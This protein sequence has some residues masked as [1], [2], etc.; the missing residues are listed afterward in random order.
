[1]DLN[2]AVFDHKKERDNYPNN[3]GPK[4]LGMNILGNMSKIVG[5]SANIRFQVVLVS[6]SHATHSD[7]T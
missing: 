6:Y 4:Y 3:R 1:L 5:G 7:K 2:A